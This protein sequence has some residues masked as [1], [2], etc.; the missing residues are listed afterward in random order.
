LGGNAGAPK[1]DTSALE[2]SLK[3]RGAPLQVL[4]IADD[5]ARGIYGY[6]LIL[7]RPDLHVVWRGN[8][9]PAEPNELAAIATGHL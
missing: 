3:G 5:A 2:R 1:H 8:Q 6:D 4:D 7:L 9:P